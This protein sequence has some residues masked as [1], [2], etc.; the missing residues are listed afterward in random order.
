VALRAAAGQPPPALSDYA[1]SVAAAS[2][3]ASQGTASQPVVVS[4]STSG[5]FAGALTLSVAGLPA[6]ASGSFSPASVAAGQSSQLT[7]AAGVSTPAGTYDL[8][9]SASDGSRSRTSTLGYTVSAAQA[10]GAGSGLARPLPLS[11]GTAFYV[12]PGG[13]DSGTG[14]SASP[15]RTVQKALS[16]LAPGQIAYVRAGVY[17]EN[18]QLS[19]AGTAASPIT[20]R[21][22]PGETAVLRPA[23]SS[24][25]YPLRLAPSA[26]NVRIQGFVIENA[27]GSST[28]NIYVDGADRIEISDCEVRFS[29]RQGIFVEPSSTEVQILRNR[30]HD[31]GNLTNAQQDHGIYIE[32]VDHLIAGNVIRDQPHGFGIQIYPQAS[33]VTAVSNTIVA[34]ALGGIVVG[35]DGGTVAADTLIV[36]NV[37]VG[38]AYGIVTYW[39]GSV[40]SGNR[41]RSNLAWNNSSGNFS[42]SGIAYSGNTVAD[43]FFLDYAGRD[44]RLG[45]G[46]PAVDRAE[47][48]FTPDRG[49]DG[50]SRPLGAGADQGA[51]ER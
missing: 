46:S 35:S 41:A 48:D 29:Q 16:T 7:L 37:L 40:G 1:V 9:V 13:S 34:N 39:G 20:I 17:A 27:I 49:V 43:P 21:N 6:G 12:A 8:V 3:S 47:L 23:A 19:R 30:I 33:R 45:A 38:N 2:V 22:Y 44:L 28:T 25:S 32:G 18:L 36:N 15:W 5:G 42:G 4:T 26:A 50:V 10:A 31:N 14:S 11:S 24:P 51:F